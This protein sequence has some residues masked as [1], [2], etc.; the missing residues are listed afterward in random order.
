M[1]ARFLDPSELWNGPV[2]TL[3]DVTLLTVTD[4]ALPATARALALSQR[5][6]R[7]GDVL[8]FSD[9]PPPADTP[10]TWRPIPPI[11]SR[12]EYSRFMLHDLAQHIETSH[13]L[14]VQ[15]DGYVLDATRWDPAF[16]DYDYIGAPWPHF[17]DGMR[18]GNGGFSLRSRRLVAACAT[19]PISNEAEDIAICHTHRR[20][21]EERFGLRFAPEE[22]ARHFAYE[23]MTP[24]GSEFGFHGGFNMIG[25]TTSRDRA[26]L[27]AELEPGL[28]NR[29][30]H[31]EIFRAALR[32][33]DFRLAWVI[34]QRLRHPQSRRR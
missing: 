10:A 19:L 27:F 24:T 30:E 11:G 7:F 16:L 15:W 32:A 9:R 33:R 5:G 2:R 29:R 22:V 1:P 6:L 20:L 23:R 25:L 13:V 28:L 4:V 14:C 21:L 12:F 31:R 17:A 26:A 8:F 34:W 18:V 3:P